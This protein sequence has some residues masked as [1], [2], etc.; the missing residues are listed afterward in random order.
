[1][2]A[3]GYIINDNGFVAVAGTVTP[4]LPSAVKEIC[5]VSFPSNVKRISRC[6]VS[7][8]P[9]HLY[10]PLVRGDKTKTYPPESQHNIGKSPFL[11]GATSLN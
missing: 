4:V 8:I 3:M 2:D 9:I 11:N 10:V 5:W 6:L 7:G 1:M